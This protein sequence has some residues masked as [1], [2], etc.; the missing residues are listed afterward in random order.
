[1]K[2]FILAIL[3]L[4][5]FG[6]KLSA[7]HITGGEMYYTY[8]G[9]TGNSF[10]YR[11]T[12]K[13]FRDRFSTGAQLDA[14]AAIAVFD[15]VTGAQTAINIVPKTNEIQL[16]LTSPS[17]CIQNPPVVHYD[18][19]FYEFDLTLPASANGYII[20]YQRCCRIN[21]INNLGLATGVGATY[22][23]EIPSTIPLL[24][25]PINNSAK[26][27]GADTV[28]VC[29]NNSFTYSFAATDADG[30]E[31]RYS[32]CNAYTGG[33]AQLPAPNPPAPPPYSSV[34]YGFPYSSANPMGSSVTVNATNGL[35]SGIAPVPG[36]Y[37]LTVCV[38]E[39]R[40][41]VIIA[42]QRKDLQVKV[43]DCNPLRAALAP[44]F[45]TCDG[46]T[47]DFSNQPQSNPA[48]TQYMW[49]FGESA[50]GSADTSFLQA[51]THTY[52][53]TGVYIVKLRATLSGG[54]CA[55]SATMRVN[56]YPGFFPGFIATGSCF[57]N[58]YQF[59]DTTNTRYGTVNSWSWNFGDAATMA[60]TSRIR[61]P[62]WTYPSPGLRDV[63]LI[64]TNSKGCI[65][66]AIVSVN[67]MNKPA[68]TLGFTD[69]LICRNDSVQLSAS[70]TGTFA[71][72]PSMNIF[73]A[74]T[75][76]PT[77]NPTT[78]TWYVVQI[79]DNGCIN[80]DS[81]RVRVVAGV[82]LTAMPDTI[83]CLTDTVRLNANS[84]GLAFQWTPA[85]T[86]N[87]PN[88][89]NPI[90]TPTAAST[91]YQVRA[92]IGSCF[93]T[94]QVVITTIP[95]PVAN[96]GADP[97][98]C[99]NGS[100]QLNG[101]MN[102][103]RFTWTP[104]SYLNNPNVLTPVSSPPRTTQY[105]LS[106]YDTLGCPKPGRDT[107]VVT[108]LPRL[109]AYAGRDTV[110]VIGQRLQFNGTGGISYV[111]SPST[112]LSNPNIFNPVGVYNASIDS[113]RYKLVVTDI[114]GC[115]DSS[116]VTV[117]VFRTNP[118]VFVPTAFTPN[119]D[120]LNDIISPIAVGIQQIKYFSIFNR[121][122]QTVFNT[123]ADRAGWDGRI[124]GTLQASG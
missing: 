119:N 5:F 36:I 102:G 14:T 69:T 57:N 98:I 99:Y 103:I 55:D 94:D 68:I 40:N 101:N 20:S 56:V 49:T 82:S 66:T 19:G 104:T 21:G 58:P 88:I 106:A 38:N 90:A 80:K 59:T 12:L 65:D 45:T 31:L 85:A 97:T 15:R 10:Q 60:D 48:G 25:A 30:D 13:L 18:I 2:H 117:R 100:V 39:V 93:F 95:Y 75:A 34:P 1:M 35:V 78:D 29:A 41:G 115:A 43:G 37:I 64:V 67:V 51:P 42:T 27:V 81:V 83:I 89:L 54:L 121:R 91:T 112:G 107:V 17:P 116:F 86:L 9:Q 3:V 79:N 87:D 72:T 71:W 6:K 105:I 24:T 28:I 32:F 114:A 108:V 109:R 122:G 4:L 118:S 52:L 120:G 47:L 16:V 84:N 123:T 76:N 22:T 46:F 73:N 26:F 53:D 44:E 62:Q 77:V 74:N 50:S 63:R 7:N 33:T 23:A 8:I 92:T 61:N 111:W 70:G 96:A 110:V 113:V 11:V 124:N